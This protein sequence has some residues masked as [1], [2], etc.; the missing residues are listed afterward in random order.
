VNFVTAAAC[1]SIGLAVGSFLNVVVWRVPRGESVVRPRSHCPACDHVL[2][3]AENVPVV[4]WVALR[5]RCR[6]CAAPIPVRYPLVEIVTAIAWGFVGWSFAD[7]PAALPAF[8]LVTAAV[9]AIAAIDLD[10]GIIPNRI[11]YPVGFALVPLLAVA[12]AGTGDWAAFGRAIGGSLAYGGLFFALWFA[13]RGRGLGYGDVRLAF[14]LGLPLGW[15]G[16]PALV[17]GVFLPFALGSVAGIV[18][19]APWITIPMLLGAAAGWSLGG[20]PVGIA[21]SDLA[22]HLAVAAGGGVLLGALTFVVAS[23][24]RLAPRGRT[25]PFGPAMALGCLVVTLAV[26]L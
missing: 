21:S 3:P 14:L 12:S 13:T 8:L 9:V 25:L 2:R 6:S 15:L 1:A 20:G 17:A 19:N 11:V 10:H 24:L 23:R 7:R 22:G 16:W 26:T 5:G 4:S 18:A